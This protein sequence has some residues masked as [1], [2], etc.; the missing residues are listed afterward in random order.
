MIEIIFDKD[1][2]Q[3]VAYDNSIRIGECDYIEIENTWNI[4]HTEVKDSYQGQGIARKLVDCIFEN[5]KKYNK[6]ANTIKCDISQATKIMCMDCSEKVIIEYFNL[7][8]YNKPTVKQV[9]FT[10]LNKL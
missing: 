8:D 4:I 6:K 1:N 5:A 3:S 7:V 2:K 9:I 10:V